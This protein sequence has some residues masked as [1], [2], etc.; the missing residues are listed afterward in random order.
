M[1]KYQYDFLFKD[2]IFF[3]Y[4]RDQTISF[5]EIKFQFFFILPLDFFKIWT[6]KGIAL[7]SFLPKIKNIW[8]STSTTSTT[9]KCVKFEK[10]AKST[11]TI[12]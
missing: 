4:Y 1:K 7:I 2:S 5:S 9:C 12:V 8:Y 6:F 3:E 10:S 11:H